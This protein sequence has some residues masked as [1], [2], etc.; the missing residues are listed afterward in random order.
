MA[1]KEEIL[2]HE[3]DEAQPQVSIEAV[4]FTL[5][6]SKTNWARPEQPDSALK[7]ALL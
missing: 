2:H 4:V 1:Q 6:I 7:S 5:D 3:S